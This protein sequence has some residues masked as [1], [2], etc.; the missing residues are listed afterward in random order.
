MKFKWLGVSGSPLMSMC[1]VNEENKRALKNLGWKEVDTETE[2]DVIFSFFHQCPSNPDTSG[3]IRIF[4]LCTT[5]H[6]ALLKECIEPY[7][8]INDTKN[9]HIF[10]LNKYI[11]ENF[12]AAGIR[13]H[14]WNHGVNLDQFKPKEREHKQPLT[15]GFIGQ[16]SPWKRYDF[17]TKCFL[18]AFS[19]DPSEGNLKLITGWS[20]IPGYKKIPQNVSIDYHVSRPDMPSFLQSLDCLVSFSYSEGY[21]MPPIETLACGTPC[22]VTDMPSMHEDPYDLLCEHVKAKQVVNSDL[23]NDFPFAPK[24]LS[25]YHQV[26]FVHEVSEAD[27][28]SALL[29]M[30][31]DIV[32]GK[33]KS[34]PALSEKQSWEAR[35]RD[36]VL[37]VIKAI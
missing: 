4:Y 22:L 9:N 34:K 35:V 23:F 8:R 19:D 7:L 2:A 18:Q 12:A 16:G 15:F 5:F 28:V 20:S 32:E 30:E 10:V 31:R 11:Q 25:K 24:D 13:T 6:N 26:P 21:N 14:V 36:Q 33:G 17:L 3:R 27:A 37:T 1:I 29:R